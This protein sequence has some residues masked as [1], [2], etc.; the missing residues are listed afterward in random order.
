M[1]A[2]GDLSPKQLTALGAL[3]SGVAIG[4]ALWVLLG[5]APA[6]ANRLEDD[7]LGLVSAPLLRP[8]APDISGLVT[9]LSSH[10]IFVLPTAPSDGPQTTIV[11][12]G[13]ARSPRRT[14]ALVSIDGRPDL[15]LEAG[16]A[17]NGVTLT[18][19]DSDKATFEMPSGRKEILLGQT[20]TPRSTPSAASTA[21]A[22]LDLIS[23]SAIPPGFRLPPPPASAPR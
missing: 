13:I 8:A 18:G 16:K 4:A 17:V 22:K 6:S 5:A 14:A 19:L 23:P 15:W 20:P 9:N 7:R 2:V 12:E 1:L 3:C 10:P 11:L 21:P